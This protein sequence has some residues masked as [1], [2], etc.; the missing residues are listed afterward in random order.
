MLFCEPEEDAAQDSGNVA[1][2]KEWYKF[3][4]LER[5]VQEQYGPWEDPKLKHHLRP[6]NVTALRKAAASYEATTGVGVNGSHPRVPLDVS[7]ECCG[8]TLRLLHKVE[9]AG[10]RPSNASTTLFF[11]ILKSA[12]S[13]RQERG[14]TRARRW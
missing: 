14:G 8:R 12:T 1:T 10:V 13:K 9:M 4:R 3:W 2:C 5:E 7:D 11:L 6:Q